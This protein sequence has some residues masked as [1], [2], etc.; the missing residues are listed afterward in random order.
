M[1]AAGAGAASA[2]EANDAVERFNRQARDWFGQMQQV[3][4][5]FAGQD[6][7]AADIS[8][9]WKQA[10]GARRRAIRSRKCSA[11]CA[12][13]GQHGLDHGCEQVRAAGWRPCSAKRGRWLSMPAFGFAREHQER[14]QALAQAQLDYQQQTERLQRADG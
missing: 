5:Q 1:V 9:A 11:R 14:W 3:A 2:A 12:G 6:A 7:D 10:L 8:Q 4:A 13:Q